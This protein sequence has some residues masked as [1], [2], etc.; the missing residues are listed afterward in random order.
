MAGKRDS[1]RARAYKQLAV[2]DPETLRG[3]SDVDGDTQE[4]VVAGL[5]KL[6]T[7]RRVPKSERELAA[8]RADQFQAVIDGEKPW[9]NP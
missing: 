4:L 2:V 1:S 8:K 3:F 6:A 7:D 5:R 9:V